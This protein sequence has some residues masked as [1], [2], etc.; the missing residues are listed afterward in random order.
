MKMSE[1]I[2]FKSEGLPVCSPYKQI[3]SKWRQE[4]QRVI[5]DRLEGLLS[6]PENEPIVKLRDPRKEG[7]Y[8]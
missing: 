2:E 3:I 7:L 8:V 4:Q 5:V 1:I 6:V